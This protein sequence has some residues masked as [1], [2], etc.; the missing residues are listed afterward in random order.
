MI[1]DVI[2]ER[3]DS[4]ST[5]DSLDINTRR[6]VN[7]IC[8]ISS[9]WEIN[10]GKTFFDAISIAPRSK[11]AKRPN[12]DEI[13]S[14]DT[15]LGLC[16]LKKLD[17][18]P[19]LFDIKITNGQ[20]ISN[21]SLVSEAPVLEFFK[22]S[23]EYAATIF[24]EFVD[25]FENNSVYLGEMDFDPPTSEASIQ[26]TKVK[27]K[28]SLMWLYGVR[29]TLTDQLSKEET[30]MFN[31]QIINDF[32]L[33]FNKSKSKSV[34]MANKVFQ[35]LNGRESNS[36]NEDIDSYLTKFI[37]LGF[38][39]HKQRIVTKEKDKQK[40]ETSSFERVTD[41]NENNALDIK[42]YIDKKF[43]DMEKKVM[44]KI[45]Q[46]EQKTNQKLDQIINILEKKRLN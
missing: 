15:C 3:H 5:S 30:K 34:E 4:N 20:K 28:T 32:L 10:N 44:D 45:D 41:P 14:L 38:I 25:E 46:V 39:P 6:K 42:A 24:A 33:N 12:L 21:I 27:D 2:S 18:E 31:P 40:S 16:N 19:C 13:V 36:S 37:G 43:V 22:Q 9:N 35:S 11:I 17:N 23:G 1:M 7:E 8:E 29:L 26:F